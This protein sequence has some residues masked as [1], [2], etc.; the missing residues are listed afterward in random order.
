MIRLHPTRLPLVLAYM[1]VMFLLSTLPSRAL[2]QL[3]LTGSL[4]DA[5]HVPLYAGLALTTLF[6]VEGRGWLRIVATAL[7]CLGF[8]FLDEWYQGFIP[9]RV[10]SLDDL[11]SDAAGTAIGIALGEGLRAVR[12]P[13]EGS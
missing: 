12:V 5:L 13:W 11:V 10:Q 1:A 6:A 2:V 3:G 4:A 7:V 9:G 8:A